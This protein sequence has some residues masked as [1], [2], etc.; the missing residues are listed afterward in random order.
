MRP[1]AEKYPTPMMIV[2]TSMT[3]A[4]IG[5]MKVGAE[6]VHTKARIKGKSANGT[7]LSRKIVPFPARELIASIL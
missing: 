3:T 1:D 6:S 5:L 7:D 4:N 2:R